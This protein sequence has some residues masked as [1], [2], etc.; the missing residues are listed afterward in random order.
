M[1]VRT[2]DTAQVLTL[3]AG[4]FARQHP[5]L[6]GRVA[7]VLLD[8]MLLPAPARVVTLAAIQ[9]AHLLPH[10]LMKGMADMTFISAVDCLMIDAHLCDV[11]IFLE[12]DLCGVIRKKSSHLKATFLCL[13]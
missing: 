6:A 12:R 4:E 11:D 10:P 13:G 2:Y 1:R 7:V 9:A 8:H 5:T 3:M